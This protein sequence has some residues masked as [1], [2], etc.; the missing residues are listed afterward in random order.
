MTTPSVLDRVR[1]IDISHHNVVTDWTAVRESGV[2]FAFI[3]ASHGVKADRKFREHWEGARAAG[4]IVGAYHY[5]EASDRFWQAWTFIDELEKVDH[6]GM[7]P[8]VLDV[9]AGKP[10]AE[11]LGEWLNEV[12]DYSG[13]CPWIYTMPAWW[14]HP[15]DVFSRFP[16]WVAHWGVSAPR[17][18]APWTDWI[19]WQTGSGLVP[20]CHGPI[21]QNVGNFSLETLQWL[22]GGVN[23]KRSLVGRNA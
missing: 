23:E 18:P 20:G 9:E 12:E 3:R 6:S 1:G 15:S 10:A 4:L 21:D 14:P 13:R 11:E 2:V 22:A 19:V 8:P 7:L 17:V 5:Y 16:L